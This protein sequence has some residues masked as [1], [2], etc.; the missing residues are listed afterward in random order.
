MDNV[1]TQTAGSS[2]ILASDWNTYVQGNFDS[3]K[4][5]HVVVA[6]NAAKSAL[7]VAEGT[8]VYQ[9]DN[10]KVFVYS[11]SAWVEV[12]DL[13]RAGALP[14]TSP[15]HLI[16]ADN[17]AKSALVASEG[18]MVYQTDNKR[19]Y[20]FNGSSWVLADTPSAASVN[21]RMGATVTFNNQSTFA[22][23][24][25]AE[26]R[27]SFTKKY[28]SSS[29][30]CTLSASLVELNSGLAQEFAM[31]MYNPTSGSSE[32][33]CGYIDGA[34]TSRRQFSGT[35]IIWSGLA[36]GTYT[37]EPAFRDKSAASSFVFQGGGVYNSLNC[38]I[39]YTL[40][41]VN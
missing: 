33:A 23:F 20:L 21:A 36:A 5:G 15:G 40:I 28:T 29:V 10:Q 39:S 22:L 1:P 31:G 16:V 9:T 35:N 17:T 37:V 3:I 7:S 24:G 41:E 14:E 25:R 27:T 19:L 2:E 13:D 30:L 32:I 38:N 11:G 8:M 6:D 18:M 34:G 4:F 12:I 26:L